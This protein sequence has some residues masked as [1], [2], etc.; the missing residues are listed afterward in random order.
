MI[1]L[2]DTFP[3]SSFEDWLTLLKKDLKSEDLHEL[4]FHDEIEELDYAAYNHRD[5]ST[6]N[7]TVPGNFPYSRG[8]K[9]TDNSWKNAHRIIVDDEKAANEKALDVLMKGADALIFELQD[10]YDLD[11]LLN[12]IGLEYIHTTFVVGNVR[13]IQHVLNGPA[14][15]APHNVSISADPLEIKGL[16]DGEIIEQLRT[17]QLPVFVANGYRIQQCGANIAQE[18]A[19]VLSVANESLYQL[20]RYGLT[21]DQAA[22]CIHFHIGIGSNYFM[23][24]AKVRAL[25]SL[26]ATIIKE[27]EPEHNCSYNTRITA[28]IGTMNKSAKDPH[29]NLLRQ[30]T[31]AMA[32]V[33][34][35]V[36]QLNV[37]AHDS[38]TVNGSSSLAER[39][40]LNIPLILKEESFMD[41]VIDPAGGSYSVE[42]LTAKVTEAAW[43]AFIEMDAQGGVMND[44]VRSSFLEKVRA[45]G[46]KR[47]AAVREGKRVVI[48]VNKFPNP[49]PE[50]NSFKPETNYLGIPEIIFERD[51]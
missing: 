8:L 36:E 6:V 33:L 42:E 38:A 43:T 3:I 29:T 7:P 31:E 44:Q 50:S 39:M 5:N 35:G 14:K 51:I 17:H 23:E 34:G 11:K 9:L 41:K 21:P 32:A 24:I 37:E 4:H 15:K 13:Q 47:L 30:T 10:N 19:F 20:I 27:Y 22:A 25:R 12:G 18:I 49:N 1:G 46:Q 45:T 48:G 16:F 2:K 28:S 40:A 26:W